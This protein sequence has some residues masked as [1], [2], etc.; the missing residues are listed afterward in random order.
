MSTP[1][2]LR[3]HTRLP[4]QQLVLFHTDCEAFVLDA[5]AHLG[6]IIRLKIVHVVAPF[7]SIEAVGV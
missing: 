1:I 2:P 6:Q 5:Q 7:N 4:A 3:L